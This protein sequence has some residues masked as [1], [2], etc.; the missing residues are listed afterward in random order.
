MG[1]DMGLSFKEQVEVYISKTR[2]RG[3][4]LVMVRVLKNEKKE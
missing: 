1:S 3:G 4:S 2:W